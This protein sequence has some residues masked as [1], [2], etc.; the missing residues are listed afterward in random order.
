LVRIEVPESHGKRRRTS[1]VKE[2]MV[3]MDG[4]MEWNSFFGGRL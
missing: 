3:M 2:E 4:L 1:E